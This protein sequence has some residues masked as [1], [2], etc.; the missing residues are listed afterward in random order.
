M[1]EQIKGKDGIG[2][3]HAKEEMARIFTVPRLGKGW[4]KRWLWY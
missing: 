4:Q 1:E 3:A 2:L